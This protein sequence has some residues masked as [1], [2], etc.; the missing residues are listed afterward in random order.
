MYSISMTSRSV[1][2]HTLRYKHQI[3]DII[4]DQHNLSTPNV[5]LTLNQQMWNCEKTSPLS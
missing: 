1:M 5:G 2:F 4:T 3:Y